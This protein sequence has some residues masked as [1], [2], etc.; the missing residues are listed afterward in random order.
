MVPCK[1][2]RKWQWTYPTEIWRTNVCKFQMLHLHGKKFRNLLNL[3]WDVRA[4]PP[5]WRQQQPSLSPWCCCSITA[6]I[7][8]AAAHRTTEIQKRGSVLA[9][10]PTWP[11]AMAGSG[12]SSM[13]MTRFVDGRRSSI[14]ACSSLRRWRRLPH[15]WIC[16]WM[17]AGPVACHA[18]C[19]SVAS[20]MAHRRRLPLPLPWSSTRRHKMRN[21]RLVPSCSGV[22]SR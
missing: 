8:K 5:C 7:S 17:G 20:S 19:S 11:A 6:Q 13:V 12:T 15:L 10:E 9:Q 3:I 14:N 2:N 21:C 4:M 1:R 18:M 16:T 22:S